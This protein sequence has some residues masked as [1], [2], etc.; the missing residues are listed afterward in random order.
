MTIRTA[1]DWLRDRGV[2]EKADDSK[3]IGF[4]ALVAKLIAKGY[5]K[6]VA[7][8]IAG[9]VYWQQKGKSKGKKKG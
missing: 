4:D 8:K 3:H 6:E 2:T 1:F 5:A 9:K 7:E